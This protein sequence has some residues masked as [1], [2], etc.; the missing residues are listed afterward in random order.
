MLADVQ[1]SW[2]LEEPAQY[3]WASMSTDKLK[4]GHTMYAFEELKYVKVCKECAKSCERCMH[5]IGKVWCAC[6]CVSDA[7]GTIIHFCS[8]CPGGWCYVW[9]DECGRLVCIL[10]RVD[11]CQEAREK[12]L[13]GAGEACWA[14]NP[15]VRG[16]KPW[17]AISFVPEK[18]QKKWNSW[19]EY[20]YIEKV[21]SMSGWSVLSNIIH[22]N[23]YYIS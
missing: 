21:E 12:V 9:R 13:F 1:Y 23:T 8:L 20:F 18:L 11:Y 19:N 14:H 22:Y 7:I 3:V 15:K 4:E 17:T 10:W 6:C 2:Q 16:S 5:D